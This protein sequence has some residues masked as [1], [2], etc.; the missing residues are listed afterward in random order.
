MSLTLFYITN[1]PA[2]ALIAEKYGTDRIWIDLETLGKAERQPGNTVKSNHTIA[3]IRA[4][5]PLLTRSELLVRVQPWNPASPEEIDSVIAAG[6]DMVML[7]MWKTPAE[8]ERFLTVVNGRAKTTL[9]LETREAAACVADALSLRP[10]EMH[11]GLNDLHLSLGRRFMFELLADGTVESLCDTIRAAGIPY[12][13]GGIAG[14]GGGMLLAEKILMEHYRLGSTRA[15]LSR[16]FC[17]SATMPPD[18]VEAVFRDQMAKLRAYETLC[19][20]ATPQQLEQNRLE[21]IMAVNQIVE[22]IQ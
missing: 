21:V 11:I 16:A 4:I 20:A 14:I 6:A 15:I 19:A 1:N 5:R 12:G 9:L 8:V 17:D 3:D 22:G 10:D 2:V 7:P 18:R 13:F